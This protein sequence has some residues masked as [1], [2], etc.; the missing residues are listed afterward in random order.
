MA[1]AYTSRCRRQSAFVRDQR[2]G[3]ASVF[4]QLKQGRRL[5]QE[6]VQAI[7]NLVASSVPDLHSNQVT[8]IDQQGHLLT[9]PQGTDDSS[10]REERFQVVQRMEDDYEQRI[11]SIVTPH[12]RRRQGTRAGG[13]AGG[14]LDH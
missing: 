3:S 8:V 10:L 9:S 5:E 6:Q 7:V 2:D 13:G 12:R 14:H 11:E 1:P 4:V